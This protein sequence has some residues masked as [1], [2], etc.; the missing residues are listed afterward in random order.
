[1]EQ[2]TVVSYADRILTGR[3]KYRIL[4]ECESVLPSD[5]GVGLLLDVRPGTVSN[6][7]SDLNKEGFRFVQTEGK[8]VWTV[9]RRPSI[10]RKH[11]GFVRTDH[12]S[13]IPDEQMPLLGDDVL[14]YRPDGQGQEG[15]S[16]TRERT[17]RPKM[18]LSIQANRGFYV[19]KLAWEAI[20]SPVR[21]SYG[22]RR[23]DREMLIIPDPNGNVK[24]VPNSN[25]E[26]NSGPTMA[27]WGFLDSIGF[28]ATE[29]KVRKFPVEI[30]ELEGGF[31]IL[32]CD[33]GVHWGG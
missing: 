9:L 10:K 16:A 18:Y 28:P 33:L 22:W 32:V 3:E 24:I 14:I 20:G 26:A 13:T 15:A 8:D 5:S 21:A 29:G 6:W 2:I 17:F 25:P 31:K 11:S 30:E 12:R 23:S 7:R 1:M 27:G 4:A 19:T